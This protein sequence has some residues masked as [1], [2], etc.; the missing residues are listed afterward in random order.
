MATFLKLLIQIFKILSLILFVFLLFIH[1]IIKDRFHSISVLFYLF[2]LP[3]LL[4]FG[5]VLLLMFY[6]KKGLRYGLLIILVGTLVYFGCHYFGAINKNVTTA[7]KSHLL[8][9]NASKNK[10]LTKAFLLKN[11]KQSNPEI[12]ALVEAE[13]VSNEDMEILEN[14]FP[15]YQF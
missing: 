10:P 5:I 1:F 11:I 13:D 6:K 9:W 4:I 8:F 2:P 7:P 15:I 14:T 12:I 3:L